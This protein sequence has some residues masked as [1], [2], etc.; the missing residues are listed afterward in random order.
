MRFLSRLCHIIALV[1]L[2]PSLHADIIV[3]TFEDLNNNGI[4]DSGES[5][6]TGLQVSAYDDHGN[7]LPFLDDAM[8]TYILPGT[9]IRSRLRVVVTG[10]N[11]RLLAGKNSAT[12]VFFAEDGETIEVPVLGK[13]ALDP[14]KTN[15]LIPCY[16]KGSSL[17]KKDSPAFDRF[18]FAARGVAKM[19]GGSGPDPIVDASISDLGS[20]W[21]VTYQSSYKRAF[22][23]SI[24]KRHVGL[25]PAGIGAVYTLDY[26]SAKPVIG[27]I[28]LQGI[29]PSLGPQIDLGSVRREVV[30]AEID[31]TMPYA[32]S[33]IEDRTRRASYDLDAFDKVGQVGYGDIEMAED[34]RTLWMVNLNQRSLMTM[35]VG[36][37]HLDVRQSL[38]K[39]VPIE[40]FPGLPNLLF[41]FRNCINAGGNSNNNGAEAFTDPNA[42][43]WDKNKYSFGGQ[44]GYSEI[45]VTNVL[46][47]ADQTSSSDLYQ[48]FKKGDFTY[49]IPVPKDESYEV[50]LHFAEPE[51]LVVGDRLFDIMHGDQM[52]VEN[53]DIVE[54]A[55]SSRKAAVLQLNVT[56]Q[57]QMIELKFVSKFS[58]KRKEALL[59]GLEIIGQTISESGILR[60]WGLT[61]HEGRGFLGVISDASYSQ[62]REHLFG[63]VLSFDP[64]NIGQGFTEELAFP[65]NY[66]RERASNAHLKNPQP[67][68]SGAWMPWASTWETTMIPT[69]GEAL[70]VQGGLLCA[71]AQ[72]IL[73]E[74]SFTSDG[75]IVVGLMDRWAHQT[76]HLNYSTY[77]GN[78]TLVIGYAVGDLLKAFKEPVGYTLEKTNTDDGV[79]Y[80]K[81]DG[82]SYNGEFF[83]EDNFISTLAHHGEII[84][85]GQAIL[86]GSDAIAVTVHSPILTKLP[87][88]QY[89]GLLTQ[90]LHFYDVSTG[91]KIGDYLFVE[92]FILGKANGLGDITLAIEAAPPSVGNYVWCDANGNGVQD[93]SEFGINDIEV[94]LHDGENAFVEIDNMITTSG[95]QFFFDN[96]LPNHRYELRINLDELQLEGY[97]GGVSPINAT[98]PL[99][100]SDA[101]EISVPGY[102]V[103]E[104]FT[105]NDGLNRDDLDFGFLGPIALDAQKILCEDV[106]IL[107]VNVPCADFSLAEIR[108]CA[109]EAPTT[110]V[111]IFP[112]FVDANDLTNEIVAD[113]RVC[114]MD[115]AVYAR[116]AVNG[117]P[118]C[119]AISEIHL[120]VQPG[121]GG[122]E[123]DFVELIC[124]MD[125]F[126]ALAYLQEQGFRGDAT[127]EFFLDDA[128]MIPFTGNPAALDPNMFPYI[129]YYDDTIIDGGCGVPGSIQLEAI[130]ASEIFA[131]ND[132]SLCGLDCIDLTLLG[133]TFYANGTGAT[134]AVWTSS[135]TGTFIEDNTFA[136]AHFY[137]PDEADLDNGQVT[138][139]LTV[140]DDPCVSP[141][142]SS[143]VVIT[144]TAGTPSFLHHPRDT[145]DCY[146]PFAA[147]PAAYDTFPGCQLVLECIDT[148][149]G[150]VVDYEILI[151]DCYDI[152]KEIKRTLK[153]TYDKQ[154]FF[155][156]DTIAVRALPDTLICP[157]MRD[158]VYCVP[159]YLKDENGHPS[160]LETGFPMAGDIPLWPQPPSECDI[161]YHDFNRDPRLLCRGVRTKNNGRRYLRRSQTSEGNDR[162]TGCADDL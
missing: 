49:N 2:L 38:I 45:P 30:D 70:N 121:A 21:G 97:S 123:V 28:D 98:G 114:G 106:S 6:V 130:P 120:M 8:G 113:I 59:A 18:P 132:T 32:L 145:I 156:M 26:T 23:A 40:D 42:V 85:G 139:S 51:D 61:F 57:N 56:S 69:I 112:S 41:R 62:S 14:N 25:G 84:T 53:F 33:T 80:R 11:A 34:G 94:T 81:D 138:L 137:C 99:I 68:R 148:L 108:L 129:L 146:H 141:P 142:P 16:E 50:L 55:G 71:Y 4:K 60:P 161:L 22:T 143:S 102:A 93:P 162:P 126:D 149:D 29:M 89:E 150:E 52:L 153:F 135:G 109:S 90:G 119:F 87:A 20:T 39:N 125:F 134:E 133:P 111:R 75:S 66:P 136:N 110:N 100:D 82:P 147:D 115:S 116:V 5:L 92:Q 131:G 37:K 155:C 1:I 83:Y 24:L 154:E 46:N 64:E 9:V 96:L 17:L 128:H 12:S 31:E 79:Y 95:G 48:T 159:G 103:I 47:S 122:L 86:P 44:A 74:I 91:R 144:L 10:Y 140:I 160:P 76:G 151:G 101:D 77:L 63:Y 124:P 19:F 54:F 43:S 118:F 127:T 58:G 152:I 27:S 104:F 35:D 78:R 7:E 117:D 72:P 3:L 73:S 13:P 36:E 67:L 88:F 158:S 105:G 15:I 65:L 157:P 107:P